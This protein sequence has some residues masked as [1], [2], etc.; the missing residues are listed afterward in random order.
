MGKTG[1]SVP[2]FPERPPGGFVVSLLLSATSHEACTEVGPLWADRGSPQSM[3]VQSF[4]TATQTVPVA[5]ASSNKYK[6]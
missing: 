6:I 4:F 2:S 5:H 3:C 1:S